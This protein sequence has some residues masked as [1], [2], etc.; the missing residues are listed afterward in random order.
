MCEVSLFS[1]D[2]KENLIKN[3][4]TSQKQ[5]PGDCLKKKKATL[6]CLTVA[7]MFDDEKQ[8]NKGN[9]WIFAELNLCFTGLD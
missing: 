8:T 9:A 5:K 3:T 2:T 1:S 6:M 7:A 4:T